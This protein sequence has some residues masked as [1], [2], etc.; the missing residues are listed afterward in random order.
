MYQPIR[1]Q[2][3]IVST[4]QRPVFTCIAPEIISERSELVNSPL[5]EGPGRQFILSLTPAALRLEYRVHCKWEINASAHATSDHFFWTGTPRETPPTKNILVV[6]E[7]V[8]REGADHG[9]GDALLHDL[10]LQRL[11]AVLV[12]LAL[13]LESLVGL[14]LKMETRSRYG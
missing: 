10:L 13:L 5:E 6:L 11:D 14:L 3:S 4:N 1:Y 2:Y 12:L 8:R 7:V 9:H